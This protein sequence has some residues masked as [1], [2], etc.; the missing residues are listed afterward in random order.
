V[1][2]PYHLIMAS[3]FAILSTVVSAV[4]A[5]TIHGVVAFTRHG[6]RTTRMFP[7]Y[8]LTNLGAQQAYNSGQ[9]YRERYVDDG[10]DSRIAGIQADEV[11]ARQVWASAPNQGLLFQ[12]AV[13]FLQGLYP[14]LTELDEELAT[15]SLTN[16]SDFT[17]PLNGYQF[18]LVQGQP[19]TNKD[20]IWI[21]GDDNCPTHIAAQK[22]YLKTPEYESV[23]NET[24]DFYS[25]FVPLLGD[26]LGDDGV[27][28]E[29]AY[30][31]FDLMNVASIHNES[32]AGEI[33]PDNL[34]QLRYLADK[35]EYN[36]NFNAS[37]PE[38]MIGGKTLLGGI[39]RQMNETV[40]SSGR[41]NK[42][43]LFSGSYD[44]FMSIFGLT[45]L[46]TVESNF[47]GLPDYA[48]TIAFEL[49]TEDGNS[50]SPA[51]FPST[52]SVND[53]LRVRFL[54]RNGT[55][56]SAQ[57]NAFPLF[58]ANEM[59]M[60]YG[61]FRERISDVAITSV[62]QWCSM[63]GS[64]QDFCVAA[65]ETAA[66]S[67]NSE[68]VQKESG[69]SSGL[70]NAAAGGIGA[71]VTLAVVL[72]VAALAFLFTRRRRAAKPAPAAQS[73]GKR[74]ASDSDEAV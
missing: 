70:S 33:D 40:S 63:C 17:A 25:Q 11:S 34:D 28:Y 68:G 53:D 36:S 5:E 45:N 41:S 18:I 4:T 29:N 26:I 14:P 37:Q 21:K 64:L 49:F 47:Y 62:A 3:K 74:S 31:V 15:E 19:A 12:T 50:D 52:E 56:G 27:T 23:L 32:I 73:E 58:A 59:S 42:F 39:L 66:D 35:W 51:D 1:P 7:G 46:T 8:S 61:Q 9:F 55:D 44:T 43:Q 20:T 16:G 60:P 72:T 38:R 22:S 67:G 71:G 69:S 30:E 2:S 24:T 48:S 54:F 10:A 65:N 6:D 13:S 57:L